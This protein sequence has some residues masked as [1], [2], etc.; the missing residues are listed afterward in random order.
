MNTELLHKFFA[1]FADDRETESIKEWVEESSENQILFFK[2]REIF[3]AI[4]L[5][6]H[7]C[8][9]HSDKSSSAKYRFLVQFL[10]IAAIV[11]ITALCSGYYFAYR[12]IDKSLAMQTISVPAGQRINITLPDGTNVWL[13]AKTTIQYPISFGQK[14]RCVSLDGQA[15][16]DVAKD[17]KHPFIVKTSK[18]QV[19]ALGTK[20]DVLAYSDDSD[21]E[22][23]L[24][25]GKV[26]VNLN[27][28]TAQSL[29]LEPDNKSFIQN[30][31]LASTK[32][33]DQSP[34][35][36]KDG[37]ICFRNQSFCDIMKSFEKT[38]DIKICVENKLICNRSLYTGK[39]RIVDGVEYALK[40]LQKDAPFGY[41][42]DS[43][44]TTIYIK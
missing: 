19:C 18:G 28:E 31:E 15:Y 14:E 30:G 3:D 42:R 1:G 32:V 23:M 12:Y 11:I 25:D 21:F 43:Q 8:E 35:Q 10:K 27:S 2:E 9:K 29:I 37:L 24:M 40:V 33:N 44:H 34:Y 16:F 22:T 26:K 41:E 20:F 13:N 36:W 38:Y 6:E 5:T 17:S 4:T 39:F 7:N